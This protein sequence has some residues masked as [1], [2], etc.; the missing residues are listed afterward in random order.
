M[1]CRIVAVERD[2]STDEVDES[3]E[4]APRKCWKDFIVEAHHS[5]S[6]ASSNFNPNRSWDSLWGLRRWG[7]CITEYLSEDEEKARYPR[8]PMDLA[9]V[10]TT[11]DL[12]D[13]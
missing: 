1:V 13:R 11:D 7:A 2:E 9:A 6:H 3:T 12:A 5:E 8:S 10:M 4:E